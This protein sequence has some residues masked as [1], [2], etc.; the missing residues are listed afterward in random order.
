MLRD[1][2]EMSIEDDA[3]HSKI[4][5]LEIHDILD[6]IGIPQESWIPEK[7]ADASAAIAQP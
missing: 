7:D 1:E 5:S 6:Q 4:T 3:S 2:I